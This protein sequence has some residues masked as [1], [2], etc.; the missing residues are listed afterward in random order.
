VKKI[1]LS[2]MGF[3]V[4]VHLSFTSSHVFRAEICASCEENY[5]TDIALLDTL[6]LAHD[7]VDPSIYLECR[8]L[9]APFH[10][11]DGTDANIDTE[12]FITY[13]N[14]DDVIRSMAILTMIS[15]LKTPKKI[16]SPIFIPMELKYKNPKLFGEYL[17][18]QNEFLNLHQNVA[19]VGL[20]PDMMD[21]KNDG[22]SAW[23]VPLR[24]Y[25]LHTG[26][27]KM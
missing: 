14:S 7:Y 13:S 21:Y 6:H 9:T 25:L 5:K 8:K 19:I 10:A 27:R 16:D 26:P 24:P 22:K 2:M 11:P 18:K 15:T 17:A 20:V 3:W 12:A 4:K 23:S 1:S